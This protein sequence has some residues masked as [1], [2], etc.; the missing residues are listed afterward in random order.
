[1]NEKEEKVGK[2]RKAGRIWLLFHMFRDRHL[3]LIKI[4]NLLKTLILP[5]VAFEILVF[6]AT[7]LKISVMFEPNLRDPLLIITSIATIAT[8]FLY[9]FVWQSLEFMWRRFLRKHES[10]NEYRGE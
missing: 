3:T 5:V 2:I 8:I 4:Y 10:E 9:F 6:L 1:M 7:S